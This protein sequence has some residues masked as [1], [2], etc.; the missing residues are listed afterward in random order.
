EFP[1]SAGSGTI[2]SADRCRKVIYLHQT[3]AQG[4]ADLVFQAAR[5]RAARRLSLGALPVDFGLL[6]GRKRHGRRL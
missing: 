2:V 6:F 3:R 4:L 5:D 1:K